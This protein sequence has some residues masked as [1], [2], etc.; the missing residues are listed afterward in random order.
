MPGFRASVE[1]V[2]G[3]GRAGVP[4]GGLLGAA[5]FWAAGNSAGA[6]SAETG[7]PGKTRTLMLRGGAL[8]AAAL[9][10]GLSRDC[11]MKTSRPACA[12][13]EMAAATAHHS[14][15]EGVVSALCFTGGH[16]W[17]HYFQQLL[18]ASSADEYAEV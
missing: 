4:S 5:G 15:W 11:D 2:S 6:N 9:R 7:D 3:L 16:G 1:V 17:A 8:A 18:A 13:R 10:F 12:V 14:L